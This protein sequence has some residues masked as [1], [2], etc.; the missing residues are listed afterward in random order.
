MKK[1]YYTKFFS[2]LFQYEPPKNLVFSKYY[3]WNVENPDEIKEGKKPRLTQYGPYVYREHRIKEDIARI[4]Y[5]K[6]F[7][8][9]HMEYIFDEK[10]TQNSGCV[11]GKNEPCKKTD[12]VTVINVPLITAI[13]LIKSLPPIPLHYKPFTTLPSALLK[14]LDFFLFDRNGCK[15]HGEHMSPLC[16]DLFYTAPVDD[17]LWQGHNPGIINL[18]VAMLEV[19]ENIFKKL[20]INIDLYKFLPIQLS[21]GTLGFYKGKNNTKLNNYRLINNGNLIH[22]K[23]LDIEELNG[24][25]DLP[26]NWWPNLAPAPSGKDSGIKG[27]FSNG[28]E[29]K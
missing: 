23:Y 13:D 22:D 12:L 19:I 28:N 25:S 5:D 16:D 4:G 11:N 1:H 18:G 21:G 3:I 15:I 17:L 6:I 7:Y 9:Q 29:I 27:I 14:V 10:E 20:G 2:L 26:D 8:G 24:N